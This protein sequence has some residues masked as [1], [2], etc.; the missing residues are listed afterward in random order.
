MMPLVIDGFW[1]SADLGIN[2]RTI[3]NSA[4]LLTS[5]DSE[6]AS[7]EKFRCGVVDHGVRVLDDA[8]SARTGLSLRERK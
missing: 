1:V 4:P 8:V 3:T 6:V 2:I 7:F 5:Y